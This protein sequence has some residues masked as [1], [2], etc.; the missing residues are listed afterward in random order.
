MPKTPRQRDPLVRVLTASSACTIALALVASGSLLLSAKVA[1]AETEAN[2]GTSAHPSE[3]SQRSQPAFSGEDSDNDG[4]TDAEEW[5]YIQYYENQPYKQWER[6]Q[7]AIAHPSIPPLDRATYEGLETVTVDVET[8]GDGSVYLGD[9]Q[10]TSWQFAKWGIDAP[11]PSSAHGGFTGKVRFN[12]IHLAA[13]PAPGWLLKRWGGD[14][15]GMPPLRLSVRMDRDLHIVAEFAPCPWT[16]ELDLLAALKALLLHTGQVATADEVFTFDRGDAHYVDGVEQYEGDGIPDAAQFLLIE[17]LL[18][19]PTYGFT[20]GV[21]SVDLLTEFASQR[22]FI[23]PYMSGKSE[24]LALASTAYLTMGGTDY[25][26]W[27][28][29]ALGFDINYTRYGNLAGRA[30]QATGDTDADNFNN[31]QEWQWVKEKSG[32]LPTGPAMARAYVAAALDPA[33]PPAGW[34]PSRG[35]KVRASGDSKEQGCWNDA[36]IPVFQLTV[37]DNDFEVEAAVKGVGDSP[38]EPLAIGVQT[39][40][41][42]GRRVKVKVKSNLEWFKEWYAPGTLL[43]G[44]TNPQDKFVHVR[45]GQVIRPV[46]RTFP[47]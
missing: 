40:V 1:A 9:G 16:G 12:Q 19:N 29:K 33:E 25:L 42:A 47:E 37:E 13:Q 45:D 21:W 28:R 22:S 36:F 35:T 41:K 34:A 18:E 30:L 7:R 44:S 27:L 39:G 38:D 46:A 26:F 5:R 11:N 8:I 4:F 14:V 17:E 2:G 20:R 10:S 3:Q 32:H 31:L 6:Y 43:H 23:S 15:E 24:K